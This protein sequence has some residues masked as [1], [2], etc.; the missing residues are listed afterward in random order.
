MFMILI[1]L[2]DSYLTHVK[3]KDGS[4]KLFTFDE[5]MEYQGSHLNVNST[6]II[7]IEEA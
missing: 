1:W 7:D 4:I 3:N 5:A 6:R 2:K